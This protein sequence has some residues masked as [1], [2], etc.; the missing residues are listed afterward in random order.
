MKESQLVGTWE[1]SVDELFVDYEFPQENG[2][3]TD[4]RWVEFLSKQRDENDAPKRL[5][6]AQFGDF[7]GA[8]FQALHYSAADL[9]QAKHPYELHKLKRK[10]TVVHLDW[11]HN[12]L[13]TG[14]CGPNTLEK[15]QLQPK[16]QQDGDSPRFEFAVILD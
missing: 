2:Q 12:G 9:D 1:K 8:S 3:R 10:E 7:S 16:K 14:S 4:V 5:L 15:Y 6:R 13:G 11:E